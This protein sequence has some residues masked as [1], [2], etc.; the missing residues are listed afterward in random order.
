MAKKEFEYLGW[1]LVSFDNSKNF[2]IYQHSLIKSYLG[3]R[4]AEVGPGNGTNLNYYYKY[5]KKIELYEP[6]KNLYLNLKKRFKQKNIKIFNKKFNSNIKYDTIIYFDVIEHIKNDTQEIKK[7]F[8]ALKKDGYL[9]ISV[10][11]FQHL[12][13]NFDKDVKHY[14]RYKKRDF[15]KILKKINHNKVNLLY[16]DSIGYVLSLM[17]K[18][19][20]SDYKK[21]FEKKIK[22]W[23]SLI[24][25]SRILDKI[26]FRSFGK[27]LLVIIKKTT[28]K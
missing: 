23:N 14:R 22:F 2:R 5:V 21:N 1:E 17:S 28:F 19:F 27:S 10:P 16:Y 25:I 9:I 24:F 4:L 3:G 6:D 18:L 11:A 20:L 26:T 13:S 7:A 8:K 15:K 12:Y